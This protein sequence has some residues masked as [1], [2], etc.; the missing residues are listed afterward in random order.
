MKGVALQY[1]ALLIVAIVS[2]Y[3]STKIFMSFAGK[4]SKVECR[5]YAMRKAMGF[6]DPALDARCGSTDNFERAD[7]YAKTHASL[8]KELVSYGIACWEKAASSPKDIWCYEIVVHPFV[9]M[10]ADNIRS[11]VSYYS[12][13]YGYKISYKAGDVKLPRAVVAVVYNSTGREVDII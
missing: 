1:F 5:T 12:S 4:S 2:L 6:E 8:A 9:N 3:A 11:S 13:E 10:P 7:I